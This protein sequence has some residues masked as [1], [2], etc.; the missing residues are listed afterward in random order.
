MP[1]DLRRSAAATWLLQAAGMACG[2]SGAFLQGAPTRFSAVWFPPEQRA[3]A[4]GCAFLGLGLGQALC[5]ALAPLI[6]GDNGDKL[7]NLLGLQLALALPPA[8]CSMLKFPDRPESAWWLDNAVAD[9]TL[10]EATP[11]TTEAATLAE[12]LVL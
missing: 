8:L 1:L 9:D 6:V 7:I 11:S 12:S 3:R 5:Y 4:T 2:I 10:H